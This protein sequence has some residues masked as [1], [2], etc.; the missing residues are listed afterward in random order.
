LESNNKQQIA[1]FRSQISL[2]AILNSSEWNF[3]MILAKY[4][5]QELIKPI[6]RAAAGWLNDNGFDPLG[7]G[8]SGVAA[9]FATRIIRQEPTWTLPDVICFFDFISSNQHDDRL[10]FYGANT[11]PLHLLKMV[12]VYEEKKAEER[13]ALLAEQKGNYT[14]PVPRMNSDQS[15]RA[16]MGKELE[17]IQIQNDDMKMVYDTPADEKFFKRNPINP[18]KK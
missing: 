1:G 11:T 13:E 9:E 5:S 18:D 10:K 14:S 7:T 3:Q 8:A 15:S 2:K 6:A 12:S 17:R 16:L 4:D